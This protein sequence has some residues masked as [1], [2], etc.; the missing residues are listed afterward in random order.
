MNV[1]PTQ[2]ITNH[3]YNEFIP[4]AN[5]SFVLWFSQKYS[6]AGNPRLFNPNSQQDVEECK[7]KL[8]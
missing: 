7:W 2:L 3:C 6:H 5:Q 1:Y 4:K 8:E